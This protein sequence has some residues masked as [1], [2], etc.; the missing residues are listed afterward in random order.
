MEFARCH[1]LTRPWQ[2]E[3]QKTRNTTLLKCCVSHA[4]WR[5]RSPKCC[6]ATKNQLTFGRRCKH[7]GCRTERV[8]TPYETCWDVTRATPATENDVTRPEADRGVAERPANTASTSKPH[9]PPRWLQREHLLR[10]GEH[11]T[12]GVFLI[13]SQDLAHFIVIKMI[14]FTNAMS[15]CHFFSP[16]NPQNVS[17]LFKLVVSDATFPNLLMSFSWTLSFQD[18]SCMTT[19]VDHS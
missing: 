9:Q 10:V 3:S 15:T 12:V 6:G 18:C 16:S 17:L 8:S 13:L 7:C 19:R 14:K 2:C 1:R 11:T 5:Q 4:K